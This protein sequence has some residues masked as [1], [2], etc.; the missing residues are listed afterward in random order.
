MLIPII[1]GVVVF[2]A[3]IIFLM[4]IYK[5]ADVDKALIITGGKK[6]VIKVS[7]GAFV[8]PIFRKADYFDL[9]MLTV[10]AEK[11]EIK[12]LTAVPI[13]ADWTAQIR[14]NI[15][16]P[17][18]LKIAIVSFKERGNEG[19]INDVRLTLTGAVRD[20]VSKM[21]PE[22]ILKDKE[23]FKKNVQDSVVDEMDN[24]GLELVSLNIQDITDNNNYFDNIAAIDSADKKQAADVKLADVDKYTRQKKAESLREAEIAEAQAKRE[25]EIAKMEA[26]IAQKEK[27]KETDMKIAEFKIQTD[28]ANANAQI[29][30]ELQETIRRQEVEEKKGAVEVMKAEQENRA[31]LKQKEVIMTRADAEKQKLTIEAEAAANV[32]KIE[33][34]NAILVSESKANAMRKEA[35]GYADVEIT[36][37]KG[38]L[39]VSE[40][41]AKGIKLVA[42]ANADRIRKE[43]QAEADVQQAKLIAEAEGIKAKKLAEAEGEKAIAEARAA[44]DK[45]NFEIEKIKIQTEAQIKVATATAEIMANVGQNAEFVNIGGG[46][47]PQGGTGNVLIDTLASIPALMKTINVENQALNGREVTGEIADLSK[48]ICSGFKEVKKDDDIPD[49]IPEDTE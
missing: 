25:T 14:P 35:E 46:A 38:K 18:K 4:C 43:G 20:I 3:L 17:E 45:V 15:N 27:R 8:I 34:D 32:K 10:K 23:S 33:A 44:N 12:T 39:S 36:K 2:I 29:A 6:P 49:D 47:L 19:I 11:D 21:T 42:E 48:A 1:V 26:E 16:D 24:M 22:Q 41:D 9:C 30:G 13:V 7:G 31:A 5:V 37:S 28:T 40:N